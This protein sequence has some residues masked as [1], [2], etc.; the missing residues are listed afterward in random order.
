[1]LRLL[2]YAQLEE[3]VLLARPEAR[4]RYI[5]RQG[6]LREV[7]PSPWTLLQQGLLSPF[8][9]LRAAT[10]PWRAAPE[11]SGAARQGSVAARR[12]PKGLSS[13]CCRRVQG[14]G[15]TSLSRP[16]LQM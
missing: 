15:L 3:E 12:S 6:R 9:L 8:G 5:W 13:P 10:E 2:R 11:A 4:R 14:L 16:C 7:K 1:M